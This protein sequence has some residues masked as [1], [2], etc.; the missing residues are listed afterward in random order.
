MCANFLRPLYIDVPIFFIANK[1]IIETS[2]LAE[3]H[4]FSLV[5]AM[6]PMLLLSGESAADAKNWQ[7]KAFQQL[8]GHSMNAY[9]KV[10]ILNLTKV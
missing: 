8:V 6:L 1:T 3:Q 4:V 2:I 7:E 10:I 9:I 5:H